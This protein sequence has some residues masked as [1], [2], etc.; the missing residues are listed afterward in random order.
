MTYNTP[1]PIS[2]RDP[3][4]VPFEERIAE[5]EEAKRDPVKAIRA[6]RGREAR[7]R[8]DQKMADARDRLLLAGGDARDWAKQEKQIRDELARDEAKTAAEAAHASFGT[9]ENFKVLRACASFA[10]SPASV[11][12]PQARVKTCSKSRKGVRLGTWRS[13]TR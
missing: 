6:Q 5:L 13:S 9:S 3:D 8:L 12:A 1:L 4:S 7:R 10:A 11:C 2:G